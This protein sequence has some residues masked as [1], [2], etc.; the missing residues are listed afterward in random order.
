MDRALLQRLQAA[1]L[2]LMPRPFAWL[3]EGLGIDEA[4]VLARVRT[5][6]ET[7]LIRQ[8]GAIFDGRC[9]GYQSTLVAFHVAENA[10]DA[11][12]AQVSAHPG[13][14]HNTARL[15]HYS[16]WFTLAVPPGQEITDEIVRLAGQTGVSDWL[17]LPALRVFKIRTYFRLEDMDTIQATAESG[18][19][20]RQLYTFTPADIPYVRALQQDLPLVPRPFAHAAGQIGVSEEALLHRAQELLLAGILRRFGAVLRHRH[21]GDVANGMACWVVPKAR[22][23][24]V[25]RYAAGFPEVSYCY[26]RAT[27]R[28]RWPYSLFT[29]IYSQTEDE[30]RGIAMQIA[31]ETEIEDYQVLYSTHEFKKERVKYFET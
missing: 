27:H 13:V 31:R 12:A 16:L 19:P 9:L 20:E 23:E 25:G 10:L 24:E 6:K 29:V 22:I 15:H 28:S 1:D 14:S 30:V 7:G 3:G 11:V 2:P 21:V 8:I 26:Q 5:L 17:N 4:Q 18:E